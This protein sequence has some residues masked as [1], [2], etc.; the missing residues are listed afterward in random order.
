MYTSGYTCGHVC[1][2]V[3]LYCIYSCTCKRVHMDVCVCACVRVCGRVRMGVCVFARMD[4]RLSLCVC[5]TLIYE[6]INCQ[7]LIRSLSLYLVY[8]CCLSSH[9]SSK[10]K[11]F[12]RQKKY[13][14]PYFFLLESSCCKKIHIF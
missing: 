5:R 1:I 12:I 7:Q 4:M 6:H 9:F 13:F 11:S 10:A 3:C 8:L 2:C 14:N